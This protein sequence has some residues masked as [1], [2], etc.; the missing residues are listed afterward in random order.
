MVVVIGEGG[1]DAGAEL[2]GFAMGELQRGYL[3]QVVMQQPRVVDQAL[4]DQR[5]PAGQRRALAAHDRAVRELG[6]SDRP[7]GR[8]RA[9][10]RPGTGLESGPAACGKPVRTPRRTLWKTT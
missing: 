3:L 9:E 8:I 4:Q 7:R 1:D 6:G 2:M 5:L 10:G